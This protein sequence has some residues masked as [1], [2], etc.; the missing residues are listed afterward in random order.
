MGKIL[1]KYEMITEKVKAGKKAEDL[2]NKVVIQVGNAT[3]ENASGSREVENEFRKLVSASGR[4]DIVIKQTA[5]TGRCAA[6]P[7]V[8]VYLPY[9]SPL[10][11][12]MVT[13][14]KVHKIFPETVLNQRLVPDYLLDKKT[15]NIYSHLITFFSSNVRKGREDFDRVAYSRKKLVALYSQGVTLPESVVDATIRRTDGVSPAFIKELMR[16]TVQF[17]IE[18]HGAGEVNNDDVDSAL[19][20]MLFSGG[21]LNLK[22]LGAREPESDQ[23]DCPA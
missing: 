3:C 4:D 21:S 22:L 5:C 11:Y 18:R 2:D 16:R 7:I 20:E 10:K 23:T 15:N 14:E 1:A 17:H 19:N 13:T 8:S 9:K 12:E 6:E